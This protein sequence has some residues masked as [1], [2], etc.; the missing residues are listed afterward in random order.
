[1]K[2]LANENFPAPSTRILRDAGWDVQ[3]IKEAM[4]GI[5]DEEVFSSL[6]YDHP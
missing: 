5:S 2:A 4:P 1:M 3:S 6:N